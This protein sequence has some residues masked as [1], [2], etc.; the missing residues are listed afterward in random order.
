MGVAE[1]RNSGHGPCVQQ[2]H[3]WA[4]VSDLNRLTFKWGFE[5]SNCTSEKCFAWPGPV[6]ATAAAAPA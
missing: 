1:F 4:W 6:T 2:P 5:R 3:R